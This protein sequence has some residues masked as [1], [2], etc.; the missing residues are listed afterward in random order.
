M[1]LIITVKYRLIM[2]GS[3]D[4]KRLVDKED[5]IADKQIPWE[6]GNNRYGTLLGVLGAGGQENLRDHDCTWVEG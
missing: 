1:Y 2:L 4:P 6:G 5:P 3:T